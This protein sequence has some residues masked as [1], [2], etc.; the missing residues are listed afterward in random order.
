MPYYNKVYYNLLDFTGCVGN[1]PST[2]HNAILFFKTN[3]EFV[4]TFPPIFYI[5]DNPNLFKIVMTCSM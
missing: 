2:I 3:I 4:L 1:Y 5:K